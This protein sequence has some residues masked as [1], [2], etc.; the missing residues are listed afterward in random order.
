MLM[1]QSS[2]L[3]CVGEIG[4]IELPVSVLEVFFLSINTFFEP[5]RMAL[6]IS[7]KKLI[8]DV[9]PPALLL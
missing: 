3:L 8:M 7:Y 6:Q 4:S 9:D 2:K 1:M 5:F